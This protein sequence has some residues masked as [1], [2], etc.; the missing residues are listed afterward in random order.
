MLLHY[1]LLILMKMT[2]VAVE[3]PAAEKALI[4]ND[5]RLECYYSGGWMHST[6]CGPLQ[7]L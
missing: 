4:E 3:A 1:T 7:Q 2:V 5:L 6:L